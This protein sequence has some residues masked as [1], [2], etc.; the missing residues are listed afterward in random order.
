MWEKVCLIFY[1]KTKNQPSN[2][3]QKALNC[4]SIDRTSGR[5]RGVASVYVRRHA[6][7]HARRDARSVTRYHFDRARHFHARF[8]RDLVEEVWPP[9]WRIGFGIGIDD[10]QT[11]ADVF[12]S[13]PWDDGED[14]QNSSSN[15]TPPTAYNASPE[16]LTIRFL[17]VKIT[18][19]IRIR[20]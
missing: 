7:T 8:Y 20:R 13:I 4:I 14:I 19:R 15:R 18:I 2:W 10:V 9:C 12:L 17:P 5:G 16:P 6:R 11:C 3:L 1:D